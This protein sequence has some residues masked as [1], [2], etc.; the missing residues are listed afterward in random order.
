[1]R[2]AYAKALLLCRDAR[3]YGVLEEL[4]RHCLE[5]PDAKPMSVPVNWIHGVL[6]EQGPGDALAW[7]CTTRLYAM[8]EEKRMLADAKHGRRV[9]D[10]VFEVTFVE[11]FIRCTAAAWRHHPLAGALA[12]WW[13]EDPAKLTTVLENRSR[14]KKRGC[15]V[16]YAEA[17]RG[18]IPA[19]K[20]QVSYGELSSLHERAFFEEAACVFALTAL[21]LMKE[22]G[23][24]V[25][26]GVEARLLAVR[27]RA[28][29]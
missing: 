17:G 29:T 15:A 23:H 13:S 9:R 12:F 19:G 5:Q 25:P 14:C 20:V 22:A 6:H 8:R 24:P 26:E 10:F 2:L 16:T 4:Y 11:G 21:E 27:A 3:G 1:M 7:E 28:G 18:K